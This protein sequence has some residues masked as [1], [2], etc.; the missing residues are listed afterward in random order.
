MKSMRLFICIIGVVLL[1]AAGCSN[2]LQHAEESLVVEKRIGNENNYKEFRE[3]VN[4]KQVQ[5]IKEI[6]KNADWI[7]EETEIVSYPDY[8][9]SFRFT[10]PNVE[11]KAVLY[12]LWITPDKKNVEITSDNGYGK[13]DEVLSVELFELIT[14]ETLPV[15]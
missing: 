9:F 6:V 13:M 15:Q 11:A 1:L 10:N 4:T 5:R 3:N 8:K 7:Q 2:D 12:Q 14:G